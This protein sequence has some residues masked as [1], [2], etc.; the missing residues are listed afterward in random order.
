MSWEVWTMKL[1]MSFFDWTLLKKNISRF[2]PAWGLA[3][4]VMILALPAGLLHELSKIELSE[5]WM[6]T[7]REIVT[8]YFEENAAFGPIFSFFAAGLFAALLFHYLHKPRAAY[9]MHA[10]PM[11]RTC[12]FVTNTVSGLLFWLVPALATGLLTHLVL[13]ANGISGC[14]GLLWEL[15]GRWF[16]QYLCLYGIAVFAMVLAGNTMIALLSCAALNGVFALLPL[17]T[18]ELVKTYC[19]GLDVSVAV[20]SLAYLAPVSAMIGRCKIEFLWIYAAVGLVLLVLAWLHY[21]RRHIE[22]AGDAMAYGWARVAFRLVF[23]YTCTLGIGFFLA[24]FFDSM[25]NPSLDFLFYALIG[26]VIG[27]FASSM[28]VERTVK[29]FRKRAV[30]LGFAVW[31]VLL[32]GTVLGLRY[33]VLGSQRRVPEAEQVASVEI[34]TN[35]HYNEQYYYTSHTSLR[36]SRDCVTLTDTA[37]VNTIRTL[38]QNAVESWEN[39]TYGTYEDGMWITLHICYHLKNGGTLR[40]V[41]DRISVEDCKAVAAIYRRPGLAVEFYDRILPERITSAVLENAEMEYDEEIGWYGTTL[42]CTQPKALRGAMLAD[43]AAGRLQIPNAFTI[44]WCDDFDVEAPDSDDENWDLE[45]KPGCLTIYYLTDPSNNDFRE[46]G[47]VW[48]SEFPLTATE[49][50]ALFK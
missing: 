3:L 33:D 31:A 37:D 38:H 47:A 40:R 19:Y 50:R 48:F 14:G 44:T 34:W 22:R 27:W 21:R 42:D 43:A 6:G 4:L 49:T 28:M 12:L 30:W 17:L 36:D 24:E 15:L 45:E 7:K 32:T 25:S 13:L 46:D 41:Y 2:A 5:I 35:E 39:G 9:M 20:D 23:T 10:F 1:K 11:T 29:V 26:C 8:E 16:L 18:L